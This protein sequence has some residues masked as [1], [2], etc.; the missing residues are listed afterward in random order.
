MNKKWNVNSPRD[1]WMMGKRWVSKKFVEEQPLL[2]SFQNKNV[3]NTFLNNL[4][5]QHCQS[6]ILISLF[7]LLSWG[8]AGFVPIRKFWK[9]VLYSS[10]SACL[11]STL[12]LS[13]FTSFQHA[14]GGW[15]AT[16]MSGTFK[17]SNTLTTHSYH[18]SQPSRSE[19]SASS[20]VVGCSKSSWSWSSLNLNL[21]ES[22]EAASPPYLPIP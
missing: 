13:F 19:C 5:T 7:P 18:A 20:S 9:V 22:K 14:K 3:L 6:F 1:G 16:R 17:G 10:A 2:S 21:T 11:S 15:N 4:W 8:T 12:L